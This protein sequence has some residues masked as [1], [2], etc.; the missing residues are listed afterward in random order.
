MGK[1]QHQSDFDLVKNP[2]LRK[3]KTNNKLLYL[4]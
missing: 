2:F 4:T 3:K 1:H